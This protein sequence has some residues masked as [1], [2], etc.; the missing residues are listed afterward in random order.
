MSEIKALNLTGVSHNPMSGSAARG[1]ISNNMREAERLQLQKQQVAQQKHQNQQQMIMAK[2][3][4]SMAQKMQGYQM[5]AMDRAE[6]DYAK[7]KKAENYIYS[8]YPK[9]ANRTLE[10]YMTNGLTYGNGSYDSARAAWEKGVGKHSWAAFEK[11]HAGNK[12]MELK[13]LQT[14]M[15]WDPYGGTSESSHNK[16]YANMLQEMTPESRHKFLNS[17]DAQTQLAFKNMYPAQYSLEER[18][19][20]SIEDLST[21]LASNPVKSLFGGATTV[22]TTG[23]LLRKQPAKVLKKLWSNNGKVTPDMGQAIK[24]ASIRLNKTGKPIGKNDINLVDLADLDI[25]EKKG[26]I[27]KAQRK[28]VENGGSVVPDAMKRENL[29]QGPV[30]KNSWEN[31]PVDHKNIKH[32]TKD[33]GKMVK[34]GVL[35]EQDAKKL[36]GIIDDIVKEGDELTAEAI[37]KRIELGGKKF[38]S[39]SNSI[40]RQEKSW[41]GGL[42]IGGLKKNIFNV[43]KGAAFYTGGGA[44]AQKA[45]ST[46][47]FDKESESGGQAEIARAI[48]S[49]GTVA[50]TGVIKTIQKKISKHG[51]QKV[52]AKVAAKGGTRLA[53]SLMGKGAVSATGVGTGIGLA[54]LSYDAYTII[55]ILDELD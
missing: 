28:I 51:I 17:M 47:G 10:D 14:S 40:A 35:N 52:L 16:K 24:S 25:M 4:H 42:S 33:I 37:G 39:L 12:A 44:L 30:G 48:G 11:H 32:V 13:S 27:S 49:E 38:K 8:H 55:K 45:A 20:T 53:L 9:M 23:Y 41:I 26:L 46:M 22:L 29:M 54:L 18:V 5:V 43:A 1:D 15:A 31:I 19:D 3:R 50:S 6:E 34:D 2:A 7:K 21:W 36:T